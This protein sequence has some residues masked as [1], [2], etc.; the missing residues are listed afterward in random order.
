MQP[1]AYTHVA[2]AH[3]YT[4]ALTNDA[5]HTHTHTRTPLVTLTHE[6]FTIHTDIYMHTYS[7]DTPRAPAVSQT[8]DAQH[9]IHLSTCACISTRADPLR[10]AATYLDE[11]E[12][13]QYVQTLSVLCRKR[14]K[15][16]FIT[17]NE[18]RGCIGR[19]STNIDVRCTWSW[20]CVY[21]CV[22][23]MCV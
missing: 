7:H 15:T 11:W 23:C 9:T 5:A 16:K 19:Y 20:V 6:V 22:V 3:T 8:H 14:K 12:S 10:K 2:I 21:V 4:Y 17:Q 18:L 1:H 13:T